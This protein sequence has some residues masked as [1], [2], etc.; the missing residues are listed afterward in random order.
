MNLTPLSGFAVK[1]GGRGCPSGAGVSLLLPVAP[2]AP[3]PANLHHSMAC[4]NSLLT[5]SPFLLLPLFTLHPVA[6]HT[7]PECKADYT[8]LGTN[9]HI[10]PLILG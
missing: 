4:R 10:V 7:S 6:G 5:E 1:K 9:L 2:P 3:S 8:L